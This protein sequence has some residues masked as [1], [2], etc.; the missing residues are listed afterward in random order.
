MLSFFT[1]RLLEW[2]EANPRELPWKE[3]RRTA[4]QIW[5]S[6]IIMQQTRLEQGAAY[7]NRFIS[8]YPDVR[9]LAAAP[10]DDVMRQW[11]GLGYYTRAR[12]LHKAAKL[13]VIEWKGNFPSSYEEIL[14]LPGVGAYSAA[15]ISSF[16]YGHSHA[17][18]DGNVKRLISRYAGVVSPINSSATQKQIQAL[19]TQYLKS[20]DPALF[21]QAIMNFG[22]LVCKPTPLCEQCPLSAKCYA[23]QNEMTNLLPVK[24]QK[25]ENTLR[26]FHFFIL[27][28]KD[29]VL[30]LHR[31][32]ADIWKGLYTPP[33]IESGSNRKP[34]GA[35]IQ[36][37][38][39]KH[40]GNI[41]YQLKFSSGSVQ[42]ILSHQTIVGKFHHV[43]LHSV[44]AKTSP[45]SIW[46]SEK[47]SDKY[48]KPKMIAE[49]LSTTFGKTNKAFV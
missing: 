41:N 43:Y 28:H 11:Q 38:L 5:L 39:S 47:S 48:G 49:Y 19:A 27:H 2:H 14:K 13:V 4:Y 17:V 45:G 9:S 21:N 40:I 6:E 32:E 30:L 36:S 18:V 26:Y 23:F 37:F 31:N 8:L 15:A 33:H 44:Q 10:F 25:K 20:A 42:Q 22:A 1:R 46:V 29:R 34:S 7:Y 3:T 35:N 24:K 16:A 12:N